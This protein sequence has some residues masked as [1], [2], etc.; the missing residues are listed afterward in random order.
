M[1]NILDVKHIILGLGFAILAQI[2]AFALVLG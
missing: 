2:G 1:S